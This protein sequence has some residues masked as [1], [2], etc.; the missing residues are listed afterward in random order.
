[1]PPHDIACV[2]HNMQLRLS[3]YSREK[4]L[5]VFMLLWYISSTDLIDHKTLSFCIYGQFISYKIYIVWFINHK[6]EFW[7]AAN[8]V[9]WWVGTRFIFYLYLLTALC[10]ARIWA[11]IILTCG[12]HLPNPA[13][14]ERVKG[15]GSFT[16]TLQTWS[17]SGRIVT[18]WCVELEVSKCNSLGFWQIS[19]VAMYN[20]IQSR[21]I[22]ADWHL[23]HTLCASLHT[24]L[25]TLESC[26]KNSVTTGTG[27]SWALRW[28]SLPLG[29]FAKT[30]AQ[31][32]P[33]SASAESTP[34]ER[35]FVRRKVVTK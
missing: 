9:M 15:G 34:G 17:P 2:F 10:G 22:S 7:S 8:I 6:V 5:I 4:F 14:S 30:W 3:E 23:L 16:F 29:A 26:H 19:I 1:M 11:V 31:P 33:S 35:V 24:W 25:L 21:W 12:H 27:Q 32:L 20:V 18:T 13:S 28:S